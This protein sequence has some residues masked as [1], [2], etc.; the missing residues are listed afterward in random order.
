ME[1]RWEHGREVT[2]QVLEFAKAGETEQA[3]K[4]IDAA[5]QQ[6]TEQNRGIWVCLLCNHPAVLAHAMGDRRRQIRYTEQ[7]LPYKKDYGF[8]AYNLA[9][10]LLDDGQV[11]L[12]KRYAT[13]AYE[14][15]IAGGTATD[16]DLNAA[17]LKLWPDVARK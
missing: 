8:A 7:A 16:R 3:L 5:L 11:D 4:V 17:I 15:S 14:S 12:A 2:R 10:L 6:A 1:G 13:E 9:K